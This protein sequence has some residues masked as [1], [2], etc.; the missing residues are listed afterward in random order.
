MIREA[1]R[2][3]G[4]KTG[5]SRP[6]GEFAVATQAGRVVG[7]VWFLVRGAFGR[8]GYVKWLGVAP[9]ARGHGVGRS[10]LEHAERR[11]FRSCA[12]VFL[13]A[14]DFNLS[15]QEFYARHGYEQ[16]GAIPDYVVKGITELVFRKRTTKAAPA[17]VV[18]KE[19]GKR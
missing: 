13:L 1:L 18:I 7:L 12:D 9:E 2:G 16:V 10:L 17:P 14:S 3:S 19:G 15:A 4:A 5:G 11:I 8:S 6:A